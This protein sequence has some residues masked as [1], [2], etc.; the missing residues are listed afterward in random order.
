MRFA[1]NSNAE[2]TCHEGDV[3]VEMTNR[4]SEN[5]REYRGNPLDD[6]SL[7]NMPQSSTPMTPRPTEMIPSVRALAPADSKNGVPVSNQ[8]D[9][10]KLEQGIETRTTVMFKNLPNK[11]SQKMLLEL[12]DE[13]HHGEYDFV[14]LRMLAV[15]L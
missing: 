9:L 10:F 7:Q 14:Y 6:T 11:L 8:V 15:R 2:D 12:L 3:G 1:D 4:A 13:T 5:I